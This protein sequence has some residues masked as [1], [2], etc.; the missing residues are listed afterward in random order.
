MVAVSTTWQ[1]NTTNT[2]KIHEWRHLR[3]TSGRVIVTFYFH[4]EADRKIDSI[5]IDSLRLRL[6]EI[7]AKD[8]GVFGELFRVYKQRYFTIVDG[9]FYTH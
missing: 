2:G 7:L 6:H 3:T 1:K 5:A 8:A 9:L 4:D